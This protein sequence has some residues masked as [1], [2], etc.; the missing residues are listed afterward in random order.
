MPLTDR[1]YMQPQRPR[2]RPRRVRGQGFDLNPV[3]VII[4]LNLLVFIITTFSRTSFAY[5]GLIPAD[6]A[7]RPWTIITAMFVHANFGH[8]LGNMITLYFFGR[9]L[10]MLV[11]NNRFL[12]VYLVGGLF[13]NVLYVLLANPL[14][15]AVGA[16]GAVYAVAGVLVV[17]TPNLRVNLYFI[18]PMPLWVV[19]VVF[20][21]LFSFIPGIAWQAHAGGLVVGLIAGYFFRKWWRK[22]YYIIR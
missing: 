8:L 3:L 6:L 21:V 4:A 7:A 16:S 20:F 15:M 9:F 14:S 17:M 10:A 19:V 13:G 2:P 18:F 1:D 11:G 12:L 5:L 22:S